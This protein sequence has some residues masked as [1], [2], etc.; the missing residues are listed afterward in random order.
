M[1][2]L[3]QISM[4]MNM[5]YFRNI[6]IWIILSLLIVPVF[7]LSTAYFVDLMTL[8]EEL[9]IITNPF[10]IAYYILYTFIFIYVIN[11]FSKPVVY[12]LRKYPAEIRKV[13][14]QD[15]EVAQKAQS[16]IPK[17]YLILFIMHIVSLWI[18]FYFIIELENYRFLSGC[19]L[20]LPFFIFSMTLTLFILIYEIGKNLNIIG[21]SPAYKTF[22]LR[23]KFLITTLLITFSA[24]SLVSALSYLDNEQNSI[25]QKMNVLK[26]V[27]QIEKD[28]FDFFFS[29]RELELRNLVNRKII[30]D[31]LSNTNAERLN[32]KV[33]NEL[34]ITLQEYVDVNPFYNALYVTD[35]NGR[36]VGTSN[37]DK[38]RLSHNI[39]DYKFVTDATI[40][41]Y[42]FG[43][44]MIQS[45]V[46][47][48]YVNIMCYPVNVMRDNRIAIGSL[49][50][51]INWQHINK[52]LVSK[53][54]EAISNLYVV[55]KSGEIL[56]YN[57]IQTFSP[58]KMREHSKTITKP[59]YDLIKGEEGANSSGYK[60][61][62]DQLVLGVWVPMNINRGWGIIIEAEITDEIL[63]PLLSALQ[64]FSSLFIMMGLLAIPMIIIVNVVLRSVKTISRASKDIADGNFNIQLDINTDDELGNMVANMNKMIRNSRNLI[65]LVVQ[66]TDDLVNS[67]QNLDELVRNSSDSFDQVFSFFSDAENYTKDQAKVVTDTINLMNNIIDSIRAV[68]DNVKSQTAVV[69]QSSSAVEEM[70]ASIENVTQIAKNA[71]KLSES[72]S[73]VAQEGAEAVS[74][75]LNG[76]MGVEGDSNKILEI[77]NLISSLSE[78]T[79]LLA[80]NAAIEAAHAGEY[81][82][83]FAVV[84]DEIRKL[85]EDS[86]KSAKDITGIVKKTA[87]KIKNAGKLAEIA[88]QGLNRILE[89][90]KSN[91]KIISEIASSMEEQSSGTNE[92][93]KSIAS[94]NEA[95]RDVNSVVGT[96]K[97]SSNTIINKI[98]DL[99]SNSNAIIEL[100]TGQ[101]NKSKVIK[102]SSKKILT[103]SEHNKSIIN[104]L[105]SILH[106]FKV[107]DEFGI[108]IKDDK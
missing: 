70:A 28:R 86:G 18:I 33:K 82:R 78:Q 56:A 23:T 44:S 62:Q 72:L 13:T 61:F 6:Y 25:Q 58:Q 96:Q 76:I 39:S 106:Q 31:T 107:E 46:T 68:S 80:M 43:Q 1:S 81:G 92:L 93:L 87:D 67:T 57:N 99:E 11:H 75:A 69:D 49:V 26:F 15:H 8:E 98:T 101:L 83:G 54:T 55:N 53:E 89:D 42:Y 84:A 66:S 104:R 50:A 108:A 51:E 22:S 79:N 30:Y 27:S 59:V 65:S 9:T 37:I 71:F 21:I 41:N 12:I 88:G 95:T 4:V 85:A 74:N 63:P 7:W 94:L 73:F 91:N 35:K 16:R 29:Q 90:V 97:E 105:E 64:S 36:V 60:N 40:G 17:I 32:P 24:G 102:D 103:I 34:S 5:K 2:K 77:V 3:R 14:R 45:K 52:L 38:L 48:D 100:I 19:Y 47:K 10:V 20:S